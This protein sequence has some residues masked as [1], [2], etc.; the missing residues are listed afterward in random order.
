[1]YRLIAMDIDGTLLN[2]A[3]EI[4]PKTKDW[5]RMAQHQGAI[6]ALVSG[7]PLPGLYREAE[8]LGLES[9]NSLLI[10]YN[11]A[12][13]ADTKSH[14]ILYERKIELT[15]A[16]RILKHLQHFPVTVMVTLGDTLLSNDPFGY[17]VQSEA[18]ANHM[19][20]ERYPDLSLLHFEPNK[21]LISA[22]PRLLAA[23]RDAI[24]KPFRQDVD[25]VISAPF[26][27]EVIVKDVHKGA[28]LAKVCELKGIKA[29]DVIAFG[30]NHN[31][32]TMIEYAGLGVAMGNAVP[33]LKSKANTVTLT[34]N[35]DGIAYVLK[36]YFTHHH[37]T[38]LIAVDMDGTFLNARMDYNRPLFRQLY[39]KMKECGIRFVVASGNQYHQLRS[40]FEDYADE[41][42]YVA[43]NGALIVDNQEKIFATHFPK[44]ATDKILN[45]LKGNPELWPV[46]CT[47]DWAYVPNHDGFYQLMSKYYHHLKKI[48]DFTQIQEPLIKVNINFPEDRTEQMVKEMNDLLEGRI[49]AVS[50]GHGTLDLIVTGFNKA[51]GLKILC[52]RYGID[53]KDILAFGDG[54]NDIEMLRFAGT[55]F[56]M[57]NAPQKVKDAADF[58]APANT[59]DGVNRI[60]QLFLE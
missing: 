15:V 49:T 33:E 47:E 26:Y 18:K 3:K 16:R 60:L 48:D 46:A 20:V 19:V 43:E 23:I 39:A 34:N 52:D 38:K 7:R 42:I 13:V 58:I 14:E 4:T 53:P 21:I 51:H 6:I 22:E 11:G 5:I 54:G 12:V 10:A 2:D 29:E 36:E 45:Y 41:L 17:H 44:D 40:F 37:E 28:T 56:A 30:D 27:L 24:E 31:D 25:F 8:I 50:S 59:E 35:D 55:S 57:A 9:E 1:M 32:L